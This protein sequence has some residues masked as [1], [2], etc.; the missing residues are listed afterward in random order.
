[1]KETLLKISTEPAIY[2]ESLRNTDEDDPQGSSMLCSLAN[3]LGGRAAATGQMQDLDDAVA[4][5]REARDSTPTKSIDIWRFGRFK[6][7]Y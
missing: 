3:T 6:A 5:L 4:L 2:H 7:D 1:M